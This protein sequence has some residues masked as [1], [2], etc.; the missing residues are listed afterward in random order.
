MQQ[1]SIDIAN[2]GIEQYKVEKDIAAFIKNK[3]DEKYNPMWHC[4]VG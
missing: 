4:V 1:D 2:Q 3:F